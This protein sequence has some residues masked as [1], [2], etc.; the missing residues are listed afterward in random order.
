MIPIW[1]L[2][3]E[4]QR[5]ADQVSAIP[6]LVFEPFIQFQYDRNFPKNISVH[7]GVRPLEK[8]VAVFLIY[9]P[10]GLAQSI[11]LTVD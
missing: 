5:L 1:K 6:L 4:V 8:K 7:H 9:Q 10:K 11:F 2:K 3:R